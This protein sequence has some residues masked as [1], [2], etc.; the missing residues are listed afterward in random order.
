MQA[1]NKQTITIARTRAA[2]HIIPLL[3]AQ[4]LELI[5]THVKIG[6]EIEALATTDPLYPILTSIP[7]L[8]VRIE[9]PRVLFRLSRWENL[10]YAKEV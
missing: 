10:D 6:E 1:L 4:L 9:V 5:P 8:A 3:A 2:Q 7:D